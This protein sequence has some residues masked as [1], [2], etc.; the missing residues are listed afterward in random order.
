MDK[1]LENKW[2]ITQLADRAGI[3]VGPW[4]GVKTDSSWGRLRVAVFSI[5]FCRNQFIVTVFSR[6]IRGP[7]GSGVVCLHSN[8][9]TIPSAPFFLG[10]NEGSPA[11]K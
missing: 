9:Q 1:D 7:T 4:S 3:L 2:K 5:H 11:F 6:M 8:P 10:I